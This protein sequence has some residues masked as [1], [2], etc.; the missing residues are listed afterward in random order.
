[1]LRSEVDVIPTLQLLLRTIGLRIVLE[2]AS[3]LSVTGRYFKHKSMA[4]THDD[5][6]RPDL[7]VNFVDLTRDNRLHVSGK[8][9]PMGV[10]RCM[11]SMSFGSLTEADSEP[12]F[13]AV[14]RSELWKTT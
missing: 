1:M 10:P 14:A 12:S 5:V 6:R 8:I 4:G 3:A 9:L 2:Q 7:H 11:P 13:G